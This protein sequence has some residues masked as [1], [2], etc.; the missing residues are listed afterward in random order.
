MSRPWVNVFLVLLA[1]GAVAVIDHGV[2]IAVT[3]NEAMQ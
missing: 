3:H 2:P 1:F